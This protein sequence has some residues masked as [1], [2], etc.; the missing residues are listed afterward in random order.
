M[1]DLINV[2]ADY[3]NVTWGREAGIKVHCST[4]QTCENFLDPDTGKP[5]NFNFLPMF[6]SKSLGVFPHTVQVYGLDDPTAGAYGNE[7]FSYIEDYLVTEAK[8]HN[9]SV[10]FYGETAYWYERNFSSFQ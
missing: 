3:V 5:V 2:F 6:A 4:G 10:A 9:R 7:N 1:L 8:K